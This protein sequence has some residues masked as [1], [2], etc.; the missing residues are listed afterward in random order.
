M[1]IEVLVHVSCHGGWEARTAH[2]AV[3][4]CEGFCGYLALFRYKVLELLVDQTILR[5]SEGNSSI[6]VGVFVIPIASTRSEP[7]WNVLALC[8]FDTS[9]GQHFGDTK[10]QSTSERDDREWDGEIGSKPRLSN[11]HWA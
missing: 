1:G 11:E 10:L 8:G 5:H 7:P 9:V 3:V 4:V 2:S 6:W